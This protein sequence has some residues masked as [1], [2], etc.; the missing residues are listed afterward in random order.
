MDVGEDILPFDLLFALWDLSESELTN[1]Q[2]NGRE[3]SPPVETFTRSDSN[4]SPP[5]RFT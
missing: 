5:P 1:Q 3:Q 4:R 2:T